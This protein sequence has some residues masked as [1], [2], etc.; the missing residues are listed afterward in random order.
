MCAYEKEI[1]VVRGKINKL[2]RSI[3]KIIKQRTKLAK[4][5][6]KIKRKYGKPIFDKKREDEILKFVRSLAVKHGLEPKSIERI[7]KEIIRLCK[8]IEKT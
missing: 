1:R 6:S 3:F 8:E 4:K 5:V 2:D 7:F